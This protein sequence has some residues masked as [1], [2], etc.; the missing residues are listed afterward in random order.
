M[1]SLGDNQVLTKRFR[2][3]LKILRDF[4]NIIEYF[5][6]TPIGTKNKHNTLTDIRKM[7]RMKESN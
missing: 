5:R 2:E 3:Y 6:K 7:G 4:S 1:H